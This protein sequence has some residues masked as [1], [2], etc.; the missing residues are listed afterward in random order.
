MPPGLEMNLLAEGLVHRWPPD[1]GLHRRTLL[2]G[3]GSSSI[4]R[5]SGLRLDAAIG[6]IE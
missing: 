3:C 4:L 2:S 5:P 6:V 1:G